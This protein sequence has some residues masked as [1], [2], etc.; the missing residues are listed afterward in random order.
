MRAR[1]GLCAAMAL[2]SIGAVGAGWLEDV[3]E[4][5]GAEAVTAA[6]GALADAG[7][8]ADVE[9]APFADVYASATRPPV[10]VWRVRAT[11]R[12]APIELVLARSGAQPLLIDDRTPNGATYVLSELEYDAV[13]GGITDPALT[14]VVRRNIALTLA[15]V[16]VVAM[17]IALTYLP[18]PKEPR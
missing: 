4:L 5:T 6:E 18:P 16:L 14:R 12:E 7:L 17:A 10:E 8:A 1:V 2:T 13:A 15:A 3:P 9:A 11:V